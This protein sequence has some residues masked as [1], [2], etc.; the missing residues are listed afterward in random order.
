M[1]YNYWMATIENKKLLFN[2]WDGESKKQFK[3]NPF[4]YLIIIYKYI[5]NN[6]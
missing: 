6:L 4:L 3:K 1:P 2:S 5:F